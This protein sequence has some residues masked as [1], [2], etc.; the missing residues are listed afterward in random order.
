MNNSN[1][2]ISEHKCQHGGPGELTAN[3]KRLFVLSHQHNLTQV[4]QKMIQEQQNQKNEPQPQLQY[5]ELIATELIV[6][7]QMI[8]T[9]SKLEEMVDMDLVKLF[10]GMATESLLLKSP[11]NTLD[12]AQIYARCGIILASYLMYIAGGNNNSKKASFWKLTHDDPTTLRSMYLGLRQT[13]YESSLA[14]LLNAQTPCDC[15]EKAIPVL[16]SQNKK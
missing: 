11:T 1:D 10:F 15:L 9:H 12:Q 6:M 7:E 16:R 4:H 2:I 8:I 5:D 14:R 3:E 13:Q